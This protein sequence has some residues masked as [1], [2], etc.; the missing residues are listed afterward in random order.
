MGQLAPMKFFKFKHDKIII[1]HLQGMKNYEIADE[2]GLTPTRVYQVL[3]DPAAQMQIQAFRREMRKSA[4][5]DIE[6]R[7]TELGIAA[8]ENIAQTIEVEIAPGHRAKKHQD[9]VSLKLLDRL[10]YTPRTDRAIE[11]TGIRM[12]RDLQERLVGA[13]EETETVHAFDEA[14]EAEWH[15]VDEPKEAV[16]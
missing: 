16:G 13:L 4:H 3:K 1:M 6:G 12:D 11:D 9:D 10:G 14:E 8:I 5:T 2:L 15:E 7:M